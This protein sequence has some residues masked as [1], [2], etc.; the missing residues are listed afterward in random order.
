MI[1]FMK[2]KTKANYASS[3]S[4]NHHFEIAILFE[5]LLRSF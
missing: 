5:V 1:N 3:K 4:H 2:I